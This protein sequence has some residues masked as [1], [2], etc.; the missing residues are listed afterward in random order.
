MEALRFRAFDVVRMRTGADCKT[1]LY[2]AECGLSMSA[3]FPSGPW[4]YYGQDYSQ[5]FTCP[6]CGTRYSDSRTVGDIVRKTS[7]LIPFNMEFKVKSYKHYVDFIVKYDAILYNA[8]LDD[9]VKSAQTRYKVIRFDCRNRQV[10]VRH[11]VGGKSKFTDEVLPADMMP[12]IAEHGLSCSILNAINGTSNA[13]KYR[14]A[15]KAIMDQL[16]KSVVACLEAHTGYKL[17]GTYHNISVKGASFFGDKQL[18]LLIL[19]TYAPDAP[20]VSTD[21]AYSLRTGLRHTWDAYR[22]LYAKMRTGTGYMDAV[23]V[24][25]NK[26]TKAKRKAIM[27]DPRHIETIYLAERITDN[28]DCQDKLLPLLMPYITSE[29]ILT[30]LADYAKYKG[31]TSVINYLERISS[32]HDAYRLI[33]DTAKNYAEMS[34]R[35]SVW[36]GRVKPLELHDITYKAVLRERN[37]CVPLV[38]NSYLEAVNVDGFDFITPKTSHDLLDLGA[39]LNN[40]VGGYKSDVNKGKCA[41][42]ACV[43]SGKPIV[44]IEVQHNAVMQAKLINNKGVYTATTEDIPN[45]LKHY[46]EIKGLHDNSH[47]LVRPSYL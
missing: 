23:A 36:R 34:N 47:D 16:R 7:P 28:I 32:R 2:C 41:I 38:D 37:E 33:S 18:R 26:P 1:H 46:M 24:N 10:I 22:G 30:L 35:A 5:Y 13:F 25:I 11:K 21:L 43:K 3:M 15:C 39:D 31:P 4:V 9:F 8:E 44:C 6:H 19:K 27:T 40:C 20:T 14:T 45:A 42:V 29:D 12:Y 17:S